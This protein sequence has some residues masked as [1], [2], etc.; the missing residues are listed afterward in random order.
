MNESARHSAR[1]T[2][3]RTADVAAQLGE[4][5]TAHVR[6]LVAAGHLQAFDASTPGSG[7]RDWR[8]RQEWVDDYLARQTRKARGSAA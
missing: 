7:R 3:L 5:S 4:C 2:W 6:A 8:F 1:R